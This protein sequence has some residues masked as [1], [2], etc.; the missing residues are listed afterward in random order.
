[1]STTTSPGT[2]RVYGVERVCVIW[3]VPRSSFYA[4]QQRKVA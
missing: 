4:E 1:M 2:G 3:G